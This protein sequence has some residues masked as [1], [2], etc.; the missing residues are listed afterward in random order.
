VLDFQS[1]ILQYSR[2]GHFPPILL[3][4]DNQFVDI[5]VQKGQSLGIFSDIVID[6]KQVQI[7]R[8]GL[9]LLYSDGLTEAVNAGGREFGLTAVKKILKSG[10]QE[11]GNDICVALWKAVKAFSGDN[12]NQDDFTT[13]VIKR[14]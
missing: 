14:E 3:D 1:G 6:Q 11:N 8:G 5:P 2:A 4:A 13:V 12:L 7:D 10:R 9:V